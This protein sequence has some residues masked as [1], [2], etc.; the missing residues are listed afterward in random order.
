MS[1]TEYTFIASDELEVPP[2][3]NEVGEDKRRE[4]MLSDRKASKVLGVT[5]L[6]APRLALVQKAS[7]ILGTNVVRSGVDWETRVNGGFASPRRN[8]LGEKFLMTKAAPLILGELAE[9][10]RVSGREGQRVVLSPRW[11][12]SRMLRRHTIS[13]ES[14]LNL[15]L[16][17]A[18][19]S[20][21]SVTVTLSPTASTFA[22]LLP[23]DGGEGS[24][25][26]LDLDGASED[27]VVDL[28]I[29][30]PP[31]PTSWPPSPVSPLTPLPPN[32]VPVSPTARTNPVLQRRRE[33]I[34]SANKSAQIL[35]VEARRAILSKM[36]KENAGR[37]GWS[38]V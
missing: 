33:M 7:K 8:R 20:P 17:S 25:P 23:E 19:S 30:P 34:R 16:P 37:I 6:R 28:G 18:P 2:T 36:E 4:L 32:G 12:S 13:C 24:G 1:P 35:G 11:K 5:V 31:V 9:R 38:G 21:S 26:S 3:V 14:G 10:E 27:T 29:V 15:L 22:E